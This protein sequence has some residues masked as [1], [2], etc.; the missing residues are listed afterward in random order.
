MKNKSIMT[1]GPFKLGESLRYAQIL[2]ESYYTTTR[3]GVYKEST[4]RT[5]EILNLWFEPVGPL[6]TMKGE[7]FFLGDWCTGLI[8]DIHKGPDGITTE[9][10]I[11]KP[12]ESTVNA[13]QAREAFKTAFQKLYC[14]ND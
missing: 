4:P 12:T 9:R 14:A 7:Y 3:A 2:A 11:Y 8:L 6:L 1:P 10:I 5:D 13:Q